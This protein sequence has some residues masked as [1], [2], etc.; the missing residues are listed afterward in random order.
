MRCAVGRPRPL[1]FDVEFGLDLFYQ[2]DILKLLNSCLLRT[3]K[4][5]RNLSCGALIRGSK[6]GLL[7]SFFIKTINQKTVDET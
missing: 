5:L 2:T 1:G 7:P 4:F 6:G 3:R